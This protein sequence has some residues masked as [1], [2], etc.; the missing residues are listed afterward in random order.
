MRGEIVSDPGLGC[1]IGGGVRSLGGMAG[2]GGEDSGVSEG[3]EEWVSSE[4]GKRRM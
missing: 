1:E 2:V 3:F 4:L